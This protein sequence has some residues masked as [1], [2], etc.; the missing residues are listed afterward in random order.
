MRNMNRVKLVWIVPI[1]LVAACT[2]STP[3]TSQVLSGIV[4]RTC[5]GLQIVDQGEQSELIN[6]AYYGVYDTDIIVSPDGR[7][8]AYSRSGK[9]LWLI[10]LG[11]MEST[12]LIDEPIRD[13]DAEIR[14]MAWSPDGQRIGMLLSSIGPTAMPE[15]STLFLFNRQSGKL[16][17]VLSGVINFA[18]IP[19]T[20][21]IA[22]IKRFGDG[23]AG[24]YVVHEN[25]EPQ[26]IVEGYMQP[27]ITVSP[28][29]DS[30]SVVLPIADEAR[31]SLFVVNL[32][33]HSVRDLLQGE[34]RDEILYPR[35][36]VW[37]PDGDRVAFLACVPHEHAST[38]ASSLVLVNVKTSQ[39]RVL[40]DGVLE[41]NA[42]S[43]DGDVIVGVEQEGTRGIV[44]VSTID[45][46]KQLV[47]QDTPANSP[48]EYR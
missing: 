42:W 34:S 47:T 15:R 31:D 16:I 2:K 39:V 33:D 20:N 23:P 36:P 3:R 6:A 1:L 40:A 12:V 24:L 7:Y 43:P 18:W 5:D 22:L 14:S 8:V 46:S 26:I 27:Y 44:Q 11:T 41:P 38:C 32:V 21:G 9:D 48:F 29:G 37:S 45:G 19:E 25:T 4:Y 17:E 13:K 30:S 10:N 35:S 28:R